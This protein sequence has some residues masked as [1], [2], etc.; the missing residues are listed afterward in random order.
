MGTTSSGKINLIGLLM[1]LVVAA[2]SP[3]V[4]VEMAQ[5]ACTGA[6][7]NVTFVINPAAAG[8][9]A[10]SGVCVSKN[11]GTTYTFTAATGYQYQS[12]A[13]SGGSLTG[14]TPSGNDVSFT[15]DPASADRS[16]A[17]SSAADSTGAIRSSPSTSP[18]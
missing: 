14:I 1:L 12:V 10:P 7:V 2:S 16:A 18:A 9:V 4:W 8:S 11:S 17:P 3:M 13:S 5:A 15:L 6:Q